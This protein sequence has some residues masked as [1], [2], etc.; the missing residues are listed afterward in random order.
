MSAALRD[1]VTAPASTY[2]IF[3]T[4]IFPRSHHAH[5]DDGVSPKQCRLHGP[6]LFLRRLK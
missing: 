4:C 5:S 1:T 2:D 3:T 6:F